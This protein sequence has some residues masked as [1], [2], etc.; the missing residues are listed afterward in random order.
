[1]SEMMVTP[2]RVEGMQAFVEK[3][4][5]VFIGEEPRPAGATKRKV[6]R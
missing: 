3:R 1:M 2:D 6:K 5:P 4:K